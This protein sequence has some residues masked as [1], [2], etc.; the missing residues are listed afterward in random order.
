MQRFAADTTNYPYFEHVRPRMAELMGTGGASTLAQAYRMACA[1]NEQIA[2]AMAQ[3]SRTAELTPRLAR[4]KQAADRA[5]KAAVSV[6]GAPYVGN[7]AGGAASK[8]RTLGEELRRNYDEL[9]GR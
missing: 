7:G 1:D 8:P 2:E 3:A 6:S 9:A 5:R 4:E